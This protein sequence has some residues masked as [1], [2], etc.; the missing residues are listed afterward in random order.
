MLKDDIIIKGLP[1]CP[2]CGKPVFVRKN[3]SKRFEVYCKNCHSH[4][5]WA[6]KTDAIIDWFLMVER[7]KE[8]T[9]KNEE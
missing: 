9:K 1:N 3:A 8:V 6:N 2:V 7:Y 4:S 5:R